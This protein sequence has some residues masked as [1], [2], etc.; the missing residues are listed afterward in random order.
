MGLCLQGV[1]LFYWFGIGV[2]ITVSGNILLLIGVAA[3][4]AEVRAGTGSLRQA[5]RKP[6]PKGPPKQG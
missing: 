6:R 2:A 3:N 5:K 1:G 4:I